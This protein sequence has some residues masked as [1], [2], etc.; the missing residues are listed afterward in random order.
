M[1]P[2]LPPNQ[3]VFGRGWFRKIRPGNVVVFDHDGIEKIKRVSE[4]KA[5]KYFML[6][7]HKQAST[8]SREFGWISRSQIRAKIFWPMTG[9]YRDLLNKKIM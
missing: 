1:M 7:D 4:V 5:A 2:T 9:K 3:L 6:G 8:D